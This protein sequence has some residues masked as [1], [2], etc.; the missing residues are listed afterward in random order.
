MIR[1]LLYTLYKTIDTHISA[2]RIEPEE[3]KFLTPT[4][5]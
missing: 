2:T 3:I 4:T 1:S 5:T